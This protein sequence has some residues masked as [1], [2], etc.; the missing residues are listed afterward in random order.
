MNRDPLAES[1]RRSGA[2]QE[3]SMLEQIVYTRCSPHRDIKSHGEVVRGDGVGVFSITPDLLRKF[4]EADI[5]SMMA[6]FMIKNG[7]SETGK[8]GLFNSYEFISL[9][10]GSQALIYEVARPLCREPRKNGRLHRGGNYIKQ[11]LAGSFMRTAAELIGTSIWDAYLQDDNYYY[12]DN[13]QNSE[14][15]FLPQKDDSAFEKGLSDDMIER[16]IHDERLPLVQKGVSFLL[17]EYEKPVGNRRILL[18][19]DIPSNVELWVCAMARLFPPFLANSLTFSTNM[20]LLDTQT[21]SML[22]YYTDVSGRL[23]P[24]GHYGENAVRHP[25]CMIVGYHPQDPFC[26]SLRQMPYSSFYMI[27]G[28]EGSTTIPDEYTCD[29]VFYWDAFQEKAYSWFRT[30][31]LTRLP[32]LRLSPGIP[33]LYDASR[34][35]LRQDRACWKYEDALSALSVL[36]K[37]G[38]FSNRQMNQ[39]LFKNLSCF[40]ADNYEK[41]ESSGFALSALA[42]AYGCAVGYE[43]PISKLLAEKIRG[44]LTKTRQGGCESIRKHILS[45]K[46][47]E[48]LSEIM[49]E[50]FKDSCLQEYISSF[51]ALPASQAVIII[52]LFYC[53]LRMCDGGMKSILSSVEKTDMVYFGIYSVYDKEEYAGYCLQKINLYPSLYCDVVSSI[54]GNIL[55]SAPGDIE[56]WWKQVVSSSGKSIVQL[57]EELC[58]TKVMT[59]RAIEDMLCCRIREAGKYDEDDYRAYVNSRK[60]LPGGEDSGRAL[61]SHMIRFLKIED[62]PILAQRIHGM[63]MGKES[64][65]ELF[66]RMDEKLGIPQ[67]GQNSTIYNTMREW[68]KVTGFGSVYCACADLLNSV[69]AARTSKETIGAL[70]CFMACRI[71]YTAAIEQSEWLSGILAAV[72]RLGDV[73]VH[74]QVMDLFVFQS[75]AKQLTYLKKYIRVSL[76]QA[77]KKEQIRRMLS[78]CELFCSS[79]NAG[80]ENQNTVSSSLLPAEIERAFTEVV[81]EIFKSSMLRQTEKYTD[82]DTRVRQKLLLILED[83]SLRKPEK[84]LFFPFRIFK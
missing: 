55:E 75:K 54:A 77:E 17:R 64:E 72:N 12:L 57:C 45:M 35:L 8:P 34:Y 81:Y 61:F 19:K 25:Y 2:E 18:I 5:D 30:S 56:K 3:Y 71:P 4:S 48:F 50:L 39:Q 73:R 1:C 46:D 62:V 80:R 38:V 32:G 15:P 42:R 74:R 65:K 52:D 36:R 44:G 16:F 24:T 84:K 82:T 63:R 78:F 27:D 58:H 49:E 53:K 13:V 70:K 66:R 29:Q 83:A 6:R 26:S 79:G 40:I 14:P 23:L 37:Y 10:G 9:P 21:D 47:T 41:E 20:S 33:D 76:E 7:A 43:K 31:V 59:L 68:E 69:Y 22:F 51:Q 11:C 28:I 67:R 60:V